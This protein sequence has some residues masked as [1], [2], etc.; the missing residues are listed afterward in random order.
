MFNHEES[1]NTKGIF[2]GGG[3]LVKEYRNIRIHVCKNVEVFLMAV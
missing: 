3:C 1:K 2:L